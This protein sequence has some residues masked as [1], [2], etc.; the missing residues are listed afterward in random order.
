MQ[1]QGDAW[2]R[3]SMD[4]HIA[5]G[6]SVEGLVLVALMCPMSKPHVQPDCSSCRLCFSHC[7]IAGESQGAGE[8]KLKGAVG[9]A[10]VVDRPGL[11]GAS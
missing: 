10:G 7:V 6:G 1:V 11:G 2:D 8:R 9:E 5:G 3:S 4:I